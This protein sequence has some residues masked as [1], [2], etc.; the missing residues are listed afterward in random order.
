M[1]M[2]NHS[3]R[4]LAQTSD[5]VRSG[6]YVSNLDQIGAPN[7]A[8]KIIPTKIHWL[9]ISGEFPAVVPSKHRLG[10]S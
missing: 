5:L 4:R 3:N 10:H 2:S 6:R 9:N 1:N 7:L 8:T